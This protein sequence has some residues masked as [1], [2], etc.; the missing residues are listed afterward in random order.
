MSNEVVCAKKQY[1]FARKKCGKK[2]STN[3][4]VTSY[5]CLLFLRVGYHPI[6]CGKNQKFTFTKELFVRPSTHHKLFSRPIS[7]PRI[8]RTLV[9]YFLVRMASIMSFQL[10]KAKHGHFLFLSKEVK[11]IVTRLWGHKSD[12]NKGRK[13]RKLTPAALFCTVLFLFVK[14]GLFGQRRPFYILTT[15][16]FFRGVS[17]NSK[18]RR[19]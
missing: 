14:S 5:S 16:D 15:S 6:Q 19:G 1:I 8:R 4:T 12:L 11:A 17:Q 3:S 13:K 7:F 10:I 2:K 9:L 18:Y